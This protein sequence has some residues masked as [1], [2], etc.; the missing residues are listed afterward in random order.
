MID[1]MKMAWEIIFPVAFMLAVGVGC[2]KVGLVKRQMVQDVNRLVFN[3]F[4]PLLNFM[5]IYSTDKTQF[6]TRD[7][8]VLLAVCSISTVGC[9]VISSLILRLRKCERS[10]QGVLVQATYQTNG[11]IF[12]LPIITALCGAD[13]LAPMSLLI[14]V[15]SPLYMVL[16]V[17]VLAPIRGGKMNLQKT[18]A[19]ILRNP[20]IIASVIA[21]VFLILEIRLPVILTDT[22]QK[23]ANVTTPLSFVVLGASLHLGGFRRNLS[24]ICGAGLVRLI[25]VP[26]LCLCAGL[27][28]GLRGTHVATLVCLMGAP[29]AVSSFTLAQTYGAD[30]SLAAEIVT[31]TT[32]AAAVT[33]FCWITFLSHFQLIL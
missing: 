32:L 4:L 28:L 10:I 21:F 11:V 14:L 29:V 15:L 33:M 17:L 18:A 6:F 30:E 22:M 24:K 20:I 16:S 31:A 5:N 8:L 27:L 3:L 9:V 12:S 23:M 2:R 7:N 13:Q 25:L 1:S 26:A 19:E